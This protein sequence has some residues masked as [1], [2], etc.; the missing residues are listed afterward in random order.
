MFMTSHNYINNKHLLIPTAAGLLVL[1]L[2]SCSGGDSISVAVEPSSAEIS[3]SNPRP[4]SIVGYTG[5]AQEPFISRDGG[6]LFFNNLNAAT[7]DNGAENDTNLHYASR[8]DDVNFQYLGLVQGAANDL[9]AGVNELEGVAS[10]DN[11][12]RFVFV[13][14]TDYLDA[15]SPNYLKSLFV[16]D[17][18]SGELLNVQAIPNLKSTRGPGEGAVLGELNFDAELHGDGQAL[19][20]VEGLFSGNPFPDAAN[21]ALATKQATGFVEDVNSPALFEAVNTSDLEY[22]PS[23]SSDQLELYFTRSV[24]LSASGF[25]IYVATRDSVMQPW[26]RVHRLTAMVGEFVEGPSISADGSLLYYHQKTAGVF[27][28]HVAQR[29]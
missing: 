10:M 7:L 21:I 28:I 12:S 16:A 24:G 26:Q 5:D 4:V 13:N 27:G 8:I 18:V 14:T 9:I 1:L 22:A 3:F 11:N 19:Y 15:S 6:L 2:T 25:A 23:I 20:Y 29:D 17:Y